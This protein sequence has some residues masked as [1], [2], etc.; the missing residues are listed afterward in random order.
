MSLDTPIII[1]HDL[2]L[3]ELEL[4][5]DKLFLRQQTKQAWLNSE[6]ST[7]DF[8][9]LLDQQGFD[10]EDLVNVWETGIKLI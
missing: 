6:V 7:S 4:E 3:E 2:S 1:T 8:L 9:D 10:I 5:I